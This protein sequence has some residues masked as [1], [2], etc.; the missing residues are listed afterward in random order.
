[1]K[2]NGGITDYQIVMDESTVTDEAKNNLTVPGK[3]FISPTRPA[4]FF[5]IDFTITQAGV[6]FDESKS[7]VIS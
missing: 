5:D 7:D 6:T 2:V 4:E 1:M 3:V